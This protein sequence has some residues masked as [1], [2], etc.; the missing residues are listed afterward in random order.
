MGDE[1]T[2][3]NE[4]PH[5][6]FQCVDHIDALE[7]AYRLRFDV[8]CVER[9]YLPPQDYPSGREIDEFDAH[10]L[11]F[12]AF[13]RAGDTVGTIRLVQPNSTGFPL[14]QHCQLHDEVIP[15][16]I[17][18]IS[19]LAVSKRYRRRAED[20]IYGITPEQ[21]MVPDPRPEERRRRPEIVLGL[22]KI[23]YQESK[24]RGITHWLAAM[25]RSLV[26]LLWRYGF[27]FEAI[28]PEVDYYGPVTPYITKIAEIE[29]DVLAIRPSIFK[30]FNE[31]L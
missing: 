18:E 2:V 24:R 19:R 17:V 15:D 3:R 30:E 5:F 14:L 16:E 25:E 29:R 12:S 4:E 11:H 10:S 31:G 22:Y 21:I 6:T 27:S 1:F 9:A 23:I 8:Y 7:S 28:G 13:N 20:D 26:R